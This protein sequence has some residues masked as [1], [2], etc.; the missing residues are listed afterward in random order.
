VAAGRRGDPKKKVWGGLVSGTLVLLERGHGGGGGVLG[1][2]KGT[3]GGG[4]C[5]GKK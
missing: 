4:V 1:I 2:V 5:G 3:E